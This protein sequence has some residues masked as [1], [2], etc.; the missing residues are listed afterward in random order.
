MTSTARTANTAQTLAALHDPALT[1]EWALDPARTTVTMRTRTM[2]G[3][4]PVSG[5]FRATGGQVRLTPGGGVTGRIEVDA[6]S[7]STGLKVRDGHL[8]GEDFLAVDDHPVLAVVVERVEGT[9]GVGVLHA[10]ARSVPVRLPVRVTRTG[11]DEVELD[12]DLEVDR[13]H[14]GIDISTRGATTMATRVSVRA[15]FTRS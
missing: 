11:A 5:T 14:V 10:K 15:R 2:W 6:A 9:T 7:V 1:G 8:R 3:L 4:L 13:S 12:A